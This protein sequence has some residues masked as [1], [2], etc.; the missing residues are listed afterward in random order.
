MREVGGQDNSIARTEAEKGEAHREMGRGERS[1]CEPK[2]RTAGDPS[3]ELPSFLRPPPGANNGKE[4]V[5]V[6]SPTTQRIKSQEVVSR[7]LSLS[8]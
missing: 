4:G 2:A 6:E 3:W 5:Q 1:Q 7:R 8:I